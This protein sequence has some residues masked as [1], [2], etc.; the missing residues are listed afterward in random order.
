LTDRIDLTG[1]EVYAKHGVLDQEQEKAQVF[2]V[3]VSAYT[4]LSVPGETD[5]LSDALD[6]STLALEVREVVGSESHRLIETV[7]GR[8]ADTILAHP[9][10]VRAVI[11]IHKPNAPIDMAFDDVSVT[12][13]RTRAAVDPG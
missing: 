7:A 3:D 12:I 4:D 13:E 1:I 8:V 5:D 2:R 6:Y 10:V 9:Q 11:T